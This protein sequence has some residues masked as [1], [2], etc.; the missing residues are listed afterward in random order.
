MLSRANRSVHLELK[1][2]LP[3]EPVNAVV[4]MLVAQRSWIL[5]QIY[6]QALQ[7]LQE[8]WLKRVEHSAAELICRGCG[9]VHVGRGGWVRRGWRQRVVQTLAGPLV[10]PLLQTTCRLCGKTRA[11]DPGWLGLRPRERYTQ[12]L[13]RAVVERAYEMSYRRSASVAQ[14]VWGVRLSASTLHGF[15][16]QRALQVS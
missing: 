14:Q 2:E 3:L 12:G 15:V 8:A 9:V 16:Q 5:Q 11:P 10:L 6:A 13:K 1:L 4:E 7:Q